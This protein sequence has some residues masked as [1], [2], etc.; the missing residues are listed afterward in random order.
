[1]SSVSL[2]RARSSHGRRRAQGALLIRPQVPWSSP[3]SST[4]LVILFLSSSPWH[5][6]LELAGDGRADRPYS[7]AS[8]ISL[9]SLH[10]CAPQVRSHGARPPATRPS[11]RRVVLELYTDSAASLHLAPDFMLV[12]HSNCTEFPSAAGYVIGSS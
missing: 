7:P 2:D 12:R 8:P 1:P 5:A 10:G 6:E 11:I 4:S 9:N 3:R